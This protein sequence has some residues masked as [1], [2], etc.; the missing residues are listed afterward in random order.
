MI[1]NVGIQFYPLLLP[2][3]QPL[4][5]HDTKDPAFVGQPG[6]YTIHEPTITRAEEVHSYTSEIA[7]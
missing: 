7:L 3:L 2:P 6:A 1:E 5:L 4:Q